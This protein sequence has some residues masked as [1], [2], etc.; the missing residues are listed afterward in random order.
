MSEITNSEQESEPNSATTA[1]VTIDIALRD[2]VKAAAERLGMKSGVTLECC[3]RKGLEQLPDALD[4][5][6]RSSDA[7]SGKSEQSAGGVSGS[8]LGQN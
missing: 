6:G 2:E 1:S 4:I 8:R 7:G 3:I 5:F